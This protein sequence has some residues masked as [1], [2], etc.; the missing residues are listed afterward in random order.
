M[1]PIDHMFFFLLLF[2]SALLIQM[3]NCGGGWLAAQ[4]WYVNGWFCSIFFVNFSFVLLFCCS[5][6]Y[7]LWDGTEL[8]FIKNLAHILYFRKHFNSS[9]CFTYTIKG[10]TDEMRFSWFIRR[11][12]HLFTHTLDSFV[13]QIKM[14]HKKRNKLIY[15]LK[16]KQQQQQQKLKPIQPKHVCTEHSWTNLQ[17]KEK[18][19][20]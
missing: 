10:S 17:M 16:S 15:I 13:S 20:K 19:K 6:F 3:R 12:P 1:E 2:F 7:K 4:Y 14:N 18:K 8:M 11:G 5:V 9:N